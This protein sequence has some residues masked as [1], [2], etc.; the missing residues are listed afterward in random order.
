MESRHQLR[1]HTERN[2]M[3]LFGEVKVCRARYFQEGN[4]SLHP[5]DARLNLPSEKYFHGLRRRVAETAAKVSFDAT[6]STIERTT[7]GKVPK[8]Q[9]EQLTIRAA[10]DFESFYDSRQK[11]PEKSKSDFLVIS[12]DGK[13]V[14]MRKDSLRESTR[15]ASERERHKMKTRL[16]RGEKSNRKR[17][18]TVAS[19]YSVA[20]YHRTPE[21]IMNVED[22]PVEPRPR[23]A[24]KRLWA[25]LTRK[26][27]DIAKDAFDEALLRDPDKA[28]RWVV[29]VDAHQQQ[30]KHVWAQIIEH[31]M[32][33]VVTPILDFT[34]VS[35][36]NRGV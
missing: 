18:A 22:G 36:D 3:T 5:L 12:L 25:S 8:L 14:V 9:A 1:R 24:N 34:C 2:L 28:R 26:P 20:E 33:G 4:A 15:K 13:G 29:L 35:P 6:V 31:G 21:Q 19:V 17:M 32:E 16:S 30:L 23:P 10:A 7:G 11:Q 27:E